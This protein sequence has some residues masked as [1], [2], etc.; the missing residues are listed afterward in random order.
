MV[1]GDSES[2]ELK[3][4]NVVVDFERLGVCLSDYINAKE[5]FLMAESAL[6][7]ELMRSGLKN[8]WALLFGNEI[9]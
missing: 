6:R 8:G 4:S 9:G 5:T 2:F 1:K 7:D 3:T